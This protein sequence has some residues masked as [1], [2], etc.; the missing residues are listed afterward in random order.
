MEAKKTPQAD[1]RGKYGLFFNIGL[2]ISVALILAAFEFKSYQKVNSLELK[3]ESDSFDK[4]LDIPI[5]VHEPPLPQKVEQPK[6]EEVPDEEE[7]MDK[8]DEVFDINLPEE[9]KIPE[10]IINEAPPVEENAEEIFEVV[11]TMP[12][13]PGGLEGW[14][15][16]LN[17]HLKYPTQAR[18]MGIGGT[19]YLYFVVNTDGSIQDITVARGIGAGCDAEAVRVLQNAP[20]WTPGKQRGKPVR[21][22][23]A[24]PIKF[25]LQ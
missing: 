5:T 7:I 18:R 17:K 23:M 15:K 11:E 8:I 9:V 16:Y 19:V 24:L 2:L 3:T 20:K 12:T 4:I 6:I 10:Y 22:K 25:Q 14:A 21:V 13:P 1:L